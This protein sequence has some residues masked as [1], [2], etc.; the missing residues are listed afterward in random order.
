MQLQGVA[1]RRSAA[2]AAMAALPSR[3]TFLG[4]PLTHHAGSAAAV[5]TAVR[6]YHATAAKAVISDPSLYIAMK[7][8]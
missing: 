6:T 1:A 2:L 7:E 4:C 8:G 5:C 3:N